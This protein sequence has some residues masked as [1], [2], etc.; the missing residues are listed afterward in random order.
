MSISSSTYPKIT[1]LDLTRHCR[2][3]ATGKAFPD[4]VYTN[5][6][7]IKKYD[8]IASDR[9]VQFSLGIEERRWGTE[10]SSELLIKAAKD[11]FSKCNIKPNQ[12]DKVIYTKL[13]GDFSFPATSL[14]VLEGLGINNGIPAIDI[15]AACSGVIHAMDMALRYIDSGD[16]YILVLG[17]DKSSMSLE[18]DFTPEAKTIFLN[19]DGVAAVLLEKT[20]NKHFIASYIYTDSSYFQYSYMPFGSIVLN[21]ENIT[22]DD[23]TFL[24]NMA[25]GQVVH[26]AI[27]DTTRIVVDNLLEEA[28][29]KIEDIDVFITCDQTHLV[30]KD[31]CK[32][33]G[34][35]EDKS[36]SLFKK[37]GNTVAAMTPLNLNA[38]IEAGKLKRGMTVL[39][40]AHGAGASGGGFIFTY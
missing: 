32:E 15:S 31:Q 7:I 11:C 4:Q 39:M 40:T 33:I 35:P 2:I 16:D 3:A 17:G 12:I 1:P 21:S 34:I 37:H 10:E 28:K 14:K 26:Q 6:D 8:L 19:G 22:L 30:W 25:N 18:V 20:E 5:D 29:M 36:I 9:A 23:S 38:M 27:L 13:K 24:M